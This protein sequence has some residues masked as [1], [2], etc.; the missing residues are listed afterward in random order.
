MT[1]DYYATLGVDK[2]ASDEDIK[3]AYRKLASQHHPDKGGTKEKFQEIQEAYSA[4][5]TSEKRAV[6]NNPQPQRQHFNGRSAEEMHDE[7]LRAMRA[8]HEHQQRNAVP[9]IRLNISIER[10]FS[11][12]TVPLSVF[13]HSIAYKL[14]AGLP[15][16][17]AY[18]DAVPVDDKQRQIQ[19]QLNIDGGRFRFLHVG[20]EDGLN[21]SG[22]LE[23]EIDVDALDILAGGFVIAQDF[24][25]KKLQVRVPSGFDPK[26]RLKIAG[27]GYTNW[28]GDKPG[29][30][31]DLYLR[32]TP[33]FKPFAEL[34]KD[35][36]EALYNLTRTPPIERVA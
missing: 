30:R 28:H 12:T 14:R 27:H 23:T 15:Q 22:D 35:K 33:R 31:G 19:V 34:D 21:F 16:G 29:P 20:S 11:G 7:I 9:F 17:V 24:L 18:S 4:L 10:A 32:V 13:G 2:A 3:K 25:G 36:I 26:L 8:A 1:K 5:E 6:Y